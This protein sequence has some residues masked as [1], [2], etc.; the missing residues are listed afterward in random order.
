MI[1]VQTL[2]KHMEELETLKAINA[3]LK[4]RLD[5]LERANGR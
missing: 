3:D 2:E 1:A 4:A 5:K